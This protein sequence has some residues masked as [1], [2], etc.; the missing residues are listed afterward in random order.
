M[1]VCHVI[2]TQSHVL[3]MN[4]GMASCRSNTV[5]C[6]VHKHWQGIMS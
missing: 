1:A 5:T 4:S 2:A 6:T 3:F